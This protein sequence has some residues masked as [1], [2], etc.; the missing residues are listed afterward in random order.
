MPGVFG[1]QHGGDHRLGGQAALDQ[2]LGRRRLNH[3]ILAGV[4]CVF[5]T[6]GHEHP[7]LRRDHVQPLRD[8]G[9]DR[10]HR[11][12]AARTVPVRGLDREVNARK[13]DWQRAAVRPALLGPSRCG[14]L[15]PLVVRRFA[16][17]FRLLDILQRQRELVWIELLGFAA[18]LHPLK[19]AQ[20]MPEAVVLGENRIPLRNRG[21]PLGE[22][23][24]QARFKRMRVWRGLIRVGAHARKRIRFARGWERNQAAGH[25][26]YGAAAG[27]GVSRACRRDQS[28]PSTSAASCEADS[29]M[30]PS[31]I[32]GQRNAPSYIVE[33][34]SFNQRSDAGPVFGSL[35]MAGEERIF[36]IEH[37]DRVILRPFFKCL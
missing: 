33:L 13:I 28:R 34:A 11:R 9:A 14:C 25:N 16:G 4:A 21:V 20:Q 3:R 35:V 23:G 2:P 19:L 6:A 30:T 26:P 8:V 12:A 32:G 37:N 17:R 29:R 27:A 36:A 31:L 5:R 10:M 24:S 15:V 7:K 18:E 22:R 1:D